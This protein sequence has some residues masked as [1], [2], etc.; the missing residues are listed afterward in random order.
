MTVT[1]NVAE[2]PSC[3]DSRIAKSQR[4]PNNTKHTQ[5]TAILQP[6]EISGS[7]SSIFKSVRSQ[8]YSHVYPDLVSWRNLRCVV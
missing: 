6:P 4:Y 5:L 1:E 7:S 3:A 8:K 2:L